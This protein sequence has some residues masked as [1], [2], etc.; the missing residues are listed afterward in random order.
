MGWGR[1]NTLLSG[2]GKRRS[3]KAH[4]NENPD[5][6]QTTFNSSNFDAL[7]GEEKQS[8]WNK[9]QQEQRGTPAGGGRMFARKGIKKVR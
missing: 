2:G 6:Y 9:Q 4:Q 1:L 5:E 3:S 7:T 8:A